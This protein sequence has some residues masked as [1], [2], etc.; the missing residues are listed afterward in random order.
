MLRSMS[1]RIIEQYDVIRPIFQGGMTDLYVAAAP[2]GDRVV[3]RFLKETYARSWIARKR[4][5]HAAD[6]MKKMDHPCIP[7]LIAQGK[8]RGRPYM[9]LEYVESKTLRE[10]LV[11]R[12]PQLDKATR[13]LLRQLAEAIYYV[14]QTGYLH[15]DVKPENILVRSDNT[16]V[17]IDFDLCVKRKRRPVRLR[18]I[19]GTP[20]YVAPEVLMRQR[21]DEQADIFSFGV[22]AYELVTRHKPFERDTLEMERAAQIDPQVSPTPLERFAPDLPRGLRDLILKSLAKDTTKRYP[23]MSSILKSLDVLR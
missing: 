10:L 17:L 3:L 12:S 4:F 18:Q 6:V 11:Q 1:D 5:L 22:V 2:S 23:A 21:A 19:P 20:A 14:H 9:I 15:L 13:P 16:I 7:R 8:A